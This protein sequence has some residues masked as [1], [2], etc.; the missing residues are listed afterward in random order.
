MYRCSVEYENGLA[1]TTTTLRIRL[2]RLRDKN[3]AMR[4]LSLAGT[5]RSTNQL[6]YFPPPSP[7]ADLTTTDGHG[8]SVDCLL[9]QL[10]TRRYTY[11]N[12][13]YTYVVVVVNVIVVYS[14]PGTKGCVFTWARP[15]I[16]G[17]PVNRVRIYTYRTQDSPW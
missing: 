17:N 14:L 4:D 15:L 8:D 13:R 2:R 7:S 10:C 6:V 1:M 12:R 16:N 5:F 11:I 9:N 3:E